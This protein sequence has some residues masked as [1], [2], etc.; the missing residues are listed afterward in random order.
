MRFLVR[1]IA[2]LIDCDLGRRLQ[3]G[4]CYWPGRR[5]SQSAARS[6]YLSAF[7]IYCQLAE[8]LTYAAQPRHVTSGARVDEHGAG[9]GG[10]GS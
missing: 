10:P 7:S 1:I 3:R 9:R 4:T 8:T 2:V 5:A 6:R